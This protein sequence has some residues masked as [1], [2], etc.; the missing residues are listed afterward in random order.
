[1]QSYFCIKN[2][3]FIAVIALLIL[4]SM[5]DASAFA[6]NPSKITPKIIGGNSSSNA[7]WSWMVALVYQSDV[8]VFCGGSLIAKDWVLTAAHCVAGKTGQAL[9]VLVNRPNVL[10]TQGE[11]I[12]VKRMV[13][14]PQFNA[15]N[16]KNDIALLKLSSPAHS[17]PIEILSPYSGQDGAGQNA[18]ALGWGNTS[19]YRQLFPDDLQQVIL[20]IVSNATCK[21]HMVGIEDDMLCAGFAEG[22]KDTCEGD[23]GGP[24]VVFDAEGGA[25]RQAA[26]TS[27]GEAECAAKGYYGVYTRLKSYAAFVA[28]AICTPSEALAAPVLSL[29]VS[30][31]LVAASWTTTDHAAH[32]KLNYAPYPQ[33]FPVQSFTPTQRNQFSINLPKG[34]AYYV[35]ITAYNGNCHSQFSNIERFS[36]H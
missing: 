35:G 16:F 24:L 28:D 19:T 31:G 6:A 34:S 23:S 8:Q 22:G 4:S 30:N 9:E 21:E 1:M 29:S 32:Y 13:I 26:I 2:A 7:D 14:H 12:A 27:F 11:R 18:L 33:G 20:P 36:V 15:I 10:S 25:W 3:Q 17:E 5:L